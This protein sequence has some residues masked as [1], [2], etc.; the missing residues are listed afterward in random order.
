M[1][2]CTRSGT[3]TARIDWVRPSPSCRELPVDSEMRFWNKLARVAR[4][5]A[6]VGHEPSP[7]RSTLTRS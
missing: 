3:T 7:R 1:V 4:L 5:V 2:T 6:P